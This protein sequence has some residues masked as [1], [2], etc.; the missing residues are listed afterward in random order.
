MLRL[1]GKDRNERTENVEA[2][3]EKAKK[4]VAADVKD[5]A[6]WYVLGNCLLSH[7]MATS[8]NP[9]DMAK[10]HKVRGPPPPRWWPG[11]LLSA[12]GVER[13]R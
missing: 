1:L 6:S 11:P 4:A 5:G 10:A 8:S 12:S 9:D 3:V 7:F 2:A 13:E